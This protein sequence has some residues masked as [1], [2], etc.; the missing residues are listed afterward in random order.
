MSEKITISPLDLRVEEHEGDFVIC[1][2]NSPV[3]TPTGIELA[4]STPALLKHIIHELREYPEICLKDGMIDGKFP[5]CA[6]MLFA[7]QKDYV[8]RRKK[9]SA[10]EYRKLLKSDPIFHSS[11]GPERENQYKAWKAASAYLKELR[12]KYAPIL[13]REEK[14]VGKYFTIRA[15]ALME[16]EEF[17]KYTSSIISELL[18]L[19]P[20][21]KAVLIYLF[22]LHYG[23]IIYPLLLILGRCEPAEYANAVL[24]T[25]AAHAGIFG[26]EEEGK[27][28][29]EI[30]REIFRRIR[31]NARTCLEYLS[32]FKSRDS[33]E[34]IIQRGESKKL[35]FK[36]TL[37]WNIRASRNDDAVTHVCMKTIAAFLNTEGG[38]LL[39]GVADDGKIAGIELDKFPNED[40]FLLH[41]FN[42]IKASMGEASAARV[43]ASMHRI[44]NKTVCRIDCNRSQKPVFLRFKKNQDEEFYIRTGPGSTKLSPSSLLGY[45]QEH[46]TDQHKA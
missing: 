22:N 38:T 36:S 28:P 35:E 27:S 45:I 18:E 23:N 25:T 8:E 13:F 41:L 26:V 37:R 39:I 9:F 40:K 32:F 11:T 24:A 10:E 19:S 7:T 6:Y 31:N 43:T 20:P 30:H 15:I 5:L 12:A 1:Y 4:D 42:V 44:K 29:E 2:G 14:D 17:E 3:K 46:F 33:I 21:Q 16:D 34:R